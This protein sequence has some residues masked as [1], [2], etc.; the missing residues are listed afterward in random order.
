MGVANNIKTTVSVSKLCNDYCEFAQ[1]VGNITAPFANLI[2]RV[3]SIFFVTK[4]NKL[5]I[6]ATQMLEAILYFVLTNV[7]GT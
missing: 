2:N 6:N 5:P 3:V 1:S 7:S 4:S